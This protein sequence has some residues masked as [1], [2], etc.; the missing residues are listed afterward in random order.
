MENGR[1][2]GEATIVKPG[3]VRYYMVYAAV[4]DVSSVQ[5]S[6]TH[7]EVNGHE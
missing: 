3:E 1:I 7:S 6:T 4:H 5:A 2:E